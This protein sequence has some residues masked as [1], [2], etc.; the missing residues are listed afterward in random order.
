M[1]ATRPGRCPVCD[2]S[3]RL[4]VE[5]A[6]KKV[7]C[8][9][10]ATILRIG[11]GSNETFV[12]TPVGEQPRAPQTQAAAPEPALAP[13]CPKCHATVQAADTFCPSCGVGLA[14]ANAAAAQ[15]AENRREAQLRRRRSARADNQRKISKAGRWLLLLGILFAVAGTMH[16]FSARQEAQRVQASL[17]TLPR[18]KVVEVKGKEISIADLR[19]QIDAEV[20]MAFAIDYLLG[21]IMLGLFVW[22][23]RSPFP[24]MLTGLCVFLVLLV[25]N[26][27]IDPSTLVQG[28]LLKALVIGGLTA[29]MS[30]ALSERAAKRW[31]DAHVASAT[32]SPRL[33]RAR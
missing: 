24:A 21:T 25:V 30:A 16:G 5:A 33:A 29:G 7:K 23:Q 17:A 4:P 9:G 22:A 31:R 13:T 19:Q 18:D 11:E 1:S 2:R 14:A 27:V 3:M 20:T 32:P 10:C 28:L 26:T 12:L 15:Q 6:G 8:A